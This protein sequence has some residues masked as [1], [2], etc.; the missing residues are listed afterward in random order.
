MDVITVC[1]ESAQLAAQS[2]SGWLDATNRTGGA[3]EAGPIDGECLPGDLGFPGPGLEGIL[4]NQGIN[5]RRFG[6]AVA[7][8]ARAVRG[9]QA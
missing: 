6:E 3:G 5:H 2:A 4:S 8:L 7:E 9:V 1:A